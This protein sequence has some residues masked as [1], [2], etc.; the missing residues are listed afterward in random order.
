MAGEDK[1]SPSGLERITYQQPGWHHV[2]NR[3]FGLINYRLQKVERLLDV[4]TTSGLQ[5]G[6]VLGWNASAQ[7]WRPM[8]P[9]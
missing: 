7:Q 9:A 4:N 3:N 2:V 5:D 6:S 1:L 8:N